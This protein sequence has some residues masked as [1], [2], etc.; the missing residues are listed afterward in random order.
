MPTSEQVSENRHK[1]V[2][3]WKGPGNYPEGPLYHP[4]D[5]CSEYPFKDV[6]GTENDVFEAVRGVFRLLGL[7]E[8]NCGTPAWNPLG[9]LI[10][11]GDTVLVKPNLIRESHASRP[12]EWEQ[13][14][15][16]PSIIRAVL[17]YVYIALR[18]NGQV[19]VA[20]GPQTDSDFAEICRRTSLMQL[21]SFFR[22]KRLD[23]S[24]LDLRREHWLQ[25]GGVTYRRCA[26]PGDP[27]GYTTIDLGEASAFREYH[28]NGRFYGADYN[29]HETAQ[30]H[31]GGRHAYV[32]CRTA[33]DADVI[34]N[35]PKMKTHK[36][37]GITLSLK[38]MVGV[39]GHR[40]CLP[41]HTL[42]TPAD[43][44][45]EFP[46]SS[47][48]S[49]IQSS[50]I[51]AFKRYLTV[52][53]GRGGYL[54]RLAVQLGRAVFGDTSEVVRSGNW[55]GNDTI[56]RT[57]LDL[58]KGLFHYDGSGNRRRVPR[59]YLTLVDGIVAGE[60]NGPSAPDRKEIGVIVAGLNPVAVDTVCATIMGFDYRK[61]PLLENAWHVDRC[62]LASFRPED[63]VCESNLPEWQ[64][65]FCDLLHARHLS[66]RPHSGWIGHIERDD[67]DSIPPHASSCEDSR[68]DGRGVCQS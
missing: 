21:A 58:N 31:S 39:N 27:L 16:H 51:T 63:V 29:V 47:H 52:T 40:N 6:A 20:D 30:Y 14:I 2:S 41:H 62:P 35:L 17:D 26:L 23:V 66:F 44:G 53:G 64:G 56:W 18:G 36:K 28:L 37:T 55:Y 65:P 59:R 1:L 42:G 48:M 49:Q 15:T 22:S 38:N 13:I 24:I 43:R 11:P 9:S 54:S 5:R 60:G 33:M 19:I 4:S 57:V 32:L 8:E 34:I 45:D 7:D 46:D 25:K 3:L 10:R 12:H 50:A 67:D 61:I 68:A